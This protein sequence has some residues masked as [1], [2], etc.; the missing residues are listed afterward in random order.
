MSD[1]EPKVTNQFAQGECACGPTIALSNYSASNCRLFKH[2]WQG[3]RC[4]TWSLPS[5][6]LEDSARLLVR[7]SAWKTHARSLKLSGEEHRVPSMRI[8]SVTSRRRRI[9]L[10][11]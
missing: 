10:G 4:P 11:K 3:Q 7:C 5:P 1:P 8:S 6:K 9:M 2:R